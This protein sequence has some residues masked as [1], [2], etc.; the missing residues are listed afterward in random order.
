MIA[1]NFVI[2]PGEIVGKI[3]DDTREFTNTVTAPRYQTPSEAG[4]WS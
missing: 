1:G 2:Q 4:I 3:G